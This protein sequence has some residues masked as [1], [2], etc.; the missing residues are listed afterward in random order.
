MVKVSSLLSTDNTF[1]L[2]KYVETMKECEE[3]EQVADKLKGDYKILI[4]TISG[5]KYT[6][7]VKTQIDIYKSHG[8]PTDIYK[9]RDEIINQWLRT[10]I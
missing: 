9:M 4:T 8:G 5:N 10:S 2:L 3:Q 6:V 1:V 7:S